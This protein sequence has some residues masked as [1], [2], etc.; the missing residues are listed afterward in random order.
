VHY[1]AGA[2]APQS[3]DVVVAGRGD[4]SSTAGNGYRGDH[5]RTIV[6]RARLVFDDLRRLDASL[7][8]RQGGEARQS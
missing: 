1:L 8:F 4:K 6:G 3:H 5:R 2:G 7:L